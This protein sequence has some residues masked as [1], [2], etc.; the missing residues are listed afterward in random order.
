VRYIIIFSLISVLLIS[1][2]S[3]N[4]YGYYPKGYNSSKVQPRY[5]SSTYEFSKLYRNRLVWPLRNRKV[6]SRFGWR[7]RGYHE[8]ID[9]S[10]R[11]GDPIYA[12][13]SGIVTFSGKLNGYGNTVVL[14]SGRLNTLYAH[15]HLTYVKKGE[16]VRYG[17][18]IAAAGNSG[19]ARGPHL[20]FEVR[21]E[22]QVKKY[23]A[24]NPLYFLR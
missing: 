15:A 1:C 3:T 20:H 16:R 6:T 18:N 10:A 12:S 8:G 7:K 23:V 19:N 2:T 4:N 11:I 9:I 17:Q 21:V 22:E 5:N 13:H 24:I 14:T